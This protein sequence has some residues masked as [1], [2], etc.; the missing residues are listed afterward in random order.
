MNTEQ[1]YAR[2][3]NTGYFLTKYE[4]KLLN[5]IIKNLP[6]TGAFFQGLFDG[7]EEVEHENVREQLNQLHK[8]RN[9]KQSPQ[10]DFMF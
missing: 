3:F 10:R 4:A 5:G 7:K 6:F 2:G 1:Q 8:I 9:E